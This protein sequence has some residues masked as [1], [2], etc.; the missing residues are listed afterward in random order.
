MLGSLT[1]GEDVSLDTAEALMTEILSGRATQAQI[2]AAIVAL[3]I[4]GESVE[5]MT[6]LVRGM[7]SA[8]V[9]LTVPD[10]TIDIVGAGG[11]P[12]RQRAA[13]NVS[14]MAAF[15]AA[16]AGA[17]VC[18]HGNR[19]ASSTSGAFDVLEALG[20]DIDLEPAR[21]EACVAET[22]IGLAFARTFHPGM[23][24]AG[25]VRA[26]IGIKTVFNI[27]GPLAHPA[28]VRRQLIGVADP[29]AARRMIEVLQKNGSTHAVLVTGDG[30]LDELS[31]TGPSQLLE[32]RDDAIVGFEYDA[33]DIG[34]EPPAPG[35]LDGG[36][37]DANAEIAR[38]VF[39]GETGAPRDIVVL[40]AGAALMVAGVSDTIGDGVALARTAIDDGAVAAKVAEVAA[41]THA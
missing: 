30:D 29:A 34:I 17:T 14:T 23:R 9:P 28:R 39:A 5:E 19:R 11:A 7:Y 25:P 41:F 37:A 38:R 26:E 8:S 2:A 31:T 20:L 33:T 6:G 16:A 18:K 3:R 35:A 15:V 36:D 27:L 32:L 1:S 21:L 13:L 12:A 4:K 22:G 10:Q 24:F 40:N